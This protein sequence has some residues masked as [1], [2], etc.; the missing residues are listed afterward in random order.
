M[1]NTSTYTG[2]PVHLLRPNCVSHGELTVDEAI[3]FAIY[4]IGIEPKP[5]THKPNNMFAKRNRLADLATTAMHQ[6]YPLTL[7]QPRRFDDVIK[8]SGRA[9]HYGKAEGSVLRTTRQL[10]NDYITQ[11]SKIKAEI[12]KKVTERMKK[13]FDIRF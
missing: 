13:E 3:D 8:G 5:Y 7:Y 6:G 12:K 1:S 10:R 9:Q 11:I 2:T 4:Y